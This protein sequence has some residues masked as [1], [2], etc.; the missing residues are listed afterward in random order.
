MGKKTPRMPTWLIPSLDDALISVASAF[1][2]MF[3]V[4]AVAR[5]AGLRTFAKMSAFD[6]AS[7]VAVGSIMASSVVSTEVSVLRAAIAI[8]V[9]VGIQTVV[10]RIKFASD[11]FE[12]LME[13]DPIL[14]MRDGRIIERNLHRSGVTQGDLIA[15][16]REA[17]VVQLSEVKAVVFETTGDVSVLHGSGDKKLDALLLEGVQ[18][19]EG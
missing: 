6:F 13:N 14:L 5:L 19:T 18:G 8:A 12:N 15:K 4:V 3:A 1:I 17:N 16:L 11:A 2:I 7:T 10:G 9:I